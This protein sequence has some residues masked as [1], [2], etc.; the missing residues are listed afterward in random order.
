M[1]QKTVNLQSRRV[2]PYRLQRE[3]MPRVFYNLHLTSATLQYEDGTTVEGQCSLSIRQDQLSGGFVPGDRRRALKDFQAALGGDGQ[4]RPVRLA[5]ATGDGTPVRATGM[6]TGS[7][8]DLDSLDGAGNLW[9]ESVT[10]GPGKLVGQWSRDDLWL[11]V[12]SSEDMSGLM[13]I[14]SYL[15]GKS[16][17][18]TRDHLI[19]SKGPPQITMWTPLSDA[20][21]GKPRRH[22]YFLLQIQPAPA[23]SALGE[24]YE[25][26]RVTL[27]VGL[28]QAAPWAMVWLPDGTFRWRSPDTTRYRMS[29]GPLQM[30]I[31]DPGAIRHAIACC[32]R[33]WEG[34]VESDRHRL[35]RAATDLAGASAINRPEDAGFLYGTAIEHLARLTARGDA[36][37]SQELLIPASLYESWE[38]EATEQ[39]DRRVADWEG[40]ISTDRLAR[41][42]K[43]LSSS[44]NQGSAFSSLE[45]RIVDLGIAKREEV[46][47]AIRSRNKLFHDGRLRGESIQDRYDEMLRLRGIATLLLYRV[48]GYEGPLNPRGRSWSDVRVVKWGSS[49]APE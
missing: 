35:S 13:T 46:R 29:A 37:I 6:W 19:L 45:D 28:W 17:T 39:L 33:F 7:S 47:M 16:G 10:I 30:G 43:K 36:K 5:G 26:L 3:G 49:E 14:S 15:K 32:A 8:M 22:P 23:T 12:F 31:L 1:T 48:I 27:A 4:V 42:K 40:D 34:A 38:K 9:M 41:L 25:R 24:F 21:L 44:V 18:V 2:R 11:A 20:H